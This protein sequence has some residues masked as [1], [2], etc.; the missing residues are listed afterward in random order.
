MD[1]HHFNFHL[2]HTQT[3]SMNQPPAPTSS[4]PTQSVPGRRLVNLKKLNFFDIRFLLE[5]RLGQLEL[6]DFTRN[7]M[8]LLHI[9]TQVMRT[10]QALLV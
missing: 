2:N 10:S 7:L 4:S 8:L 5:H 6:E 3:L 9:R 1:P